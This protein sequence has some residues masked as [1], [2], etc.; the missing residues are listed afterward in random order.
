MPI[1]TAATPLSLQY[2]TKGGGRVQVPVFFVNTGLYLQIESV[3]S[4]FCREYP[5]LPVTD[6]LYYNYFCSVK[7]SILLAP[8]LLNYKHQV[9]EILQIV[10]SDCEL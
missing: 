8:K 2:K 1:A 4:P 3:L 5:S 7:K 6:V 9:P 10:S